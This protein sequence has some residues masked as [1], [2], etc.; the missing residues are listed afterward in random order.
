[1]QHQTSKTLKNRKRGMA[2]S[3]YYV[4]NYNERLK[5]PSADRQ[6]KQTEKLIK[7]GGRDRKRLVNP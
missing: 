4:N 6:A 5:A 3:A 1:M 7:N 2:Y